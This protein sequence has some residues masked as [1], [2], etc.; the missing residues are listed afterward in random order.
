MSICYAVIKDHGGLITVDSTIGAGTLFHIYLPADGHD[1]MAPE[2]PVV[3]SARITTGKGRL[4]FMDDDDGVRDVIVEILVHL[5]YEVRYAK[6]G[7]EAIRLYTEAAKEAKPFDVVI[8][9]LTVQDG[10]GGQELVERLHRL[11]P[12]VRAIISSGYSNDPVLYD[13][14]QHGFL[15]VVAKPYKIEE[16]CSVLD[17]VMQGTA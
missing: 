6:D 12:G 3:S 14:R 5:G 11:D 15:G 13:F 8:A 16:L 7:A 9:D 4:L 10:M 1:E 2:I 17:D